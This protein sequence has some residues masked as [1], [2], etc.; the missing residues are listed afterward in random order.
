[1]P[2]STSAATG[3]GCAAAGP[4]TA[5][6]RSAC[7]WLVRLVD[8]RLRT[9]SSLLMIEQDALVEVVAK[10]LA[11]GCGIRWRQKVGTQDF[12]PDRIGFGFLEILA[13]VVA[14]AWPSKS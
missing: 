7:N 11:H 9:A 13:L 2:A 3:V 6:Q 1:M 10:Q 8:L 4:R 12:G 14:V 5:A